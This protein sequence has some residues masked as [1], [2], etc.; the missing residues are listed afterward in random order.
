[1]GRTHFTDFSHIT[2]T[3]VTLRRRLGCVARRWCGSPCSVL[4]PEGVGS[5]QRPQSWCLYGFTAVP[6][7]CLVVA[8]LAMICISTIST[9][10]NIPSSWSHVALDVLRRY[11][12]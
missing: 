12:A 8:L 6:R 2:P 7:C 5:W 1:M 9:S 4:L 11:D 3:R 10:G